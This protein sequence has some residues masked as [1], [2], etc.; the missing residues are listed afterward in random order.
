MKAMKD[1]CIQAHCIQAC[2]YG[3]I[4]KERDALKEQLYETNG[5]GG[6]LDRL[7]KRE[8]E[9]NRLEVEVIKLIGHI[10]R[11][12]YDLAGDKVP[13]QNNDSTCLE[14]EKHAIELQQTESSLNREVTKNTKMKFD[15]N[16]LCKYFKVENLAEFMLMSYTVIHF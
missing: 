1:N 16:F 11:S 15:L 2:M 6:L 4:V 5:N 8:I 13:E 14:C 7:K 9:A 12:G 10:Q 3:N